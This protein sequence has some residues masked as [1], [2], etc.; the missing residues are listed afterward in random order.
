MIPFAWSGFMCDKD[1]QYH[2][3]DACMDKN[4]KYVLAIKQNLKFISIKFRI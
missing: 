4:Q 1:V 2:V 3:L